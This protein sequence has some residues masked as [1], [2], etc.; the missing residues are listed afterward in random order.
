VLIVSA[1]VLVL[2]PR[3]RYG[4]GAAVAGPATPTPQR[5]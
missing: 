4:V 3:Y 5:A 1:V 2:L